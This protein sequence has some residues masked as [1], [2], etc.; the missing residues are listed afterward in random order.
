[1][2]L[3][4]CVPNFSEGRNRSTIR[5]IVRALEG[6]PGHSVLNVDM[7]WDA[8]RTVVT[9]VC[10]PETVVEAAVSGIS[11]AG[12]L[13]D[14]R[15]HSGAHPRIGST[16]VFPLIPLYQTT[17]DQCI[18]LSRQLGERI[19]EELRIP[20]FLYGDSATRPTRRRLHGIRAGQYES[21]I[22][23]I[24]KPGWE[25]DYGPAFLHPKAG[26]VAIGARPLLIAYNVNLD[27]NNLNV[28]KKIAAAVRETGGISEKRDYSGGKTG[29][30]KACQA[31][32]WNMP[33]YGF[34]Q[35]SMNLTDY[36]LTPPH[37][38]YETCKT[39]AGEQGVAVKGSEL[40]GMIPLQAMLVAGHYYA[41]QTAQ[42]AADDAALI[43]IAVEQMGLSSVRKF[44]PRKKILEYRIQEKLGL[45]IEN[46][47]PDP[48]F[49]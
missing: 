36:R 5:A 39:L 16:D 9:T 2:K 28:A 7:G 3:I 34:T 19:G 22:Q 15:R 27:T 31:I 26:A 30:L 21:L 14:M 6:K 24:G 1:M 44:L 35:V 32:G 38:A 40:I 43:R 11:E 25:P 46:L 41:S 37:I 29:R 49:Y 23:N 13:I 12:R 8:N 33:E 42:N 10:T 45:H 18:T 4:E 17:I 47:F 20:V 48:D